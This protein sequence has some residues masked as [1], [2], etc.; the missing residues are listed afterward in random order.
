MEF[1][2]RSKN[3]I[4]KCRARNTITSKEITKILPI[5]SKI[6]TWGDEIYFKIPSII[7]NLEKDSKDVLNLG[8]IAYWNQGNSV[9]IGFGPTPASKNQEIRLASNCNVWADAINPEELLNLSNLEDN[10]DIQIIFS[11]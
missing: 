11:K 7:S 10:D 2:I 8:E 6:N 4:I 9:A 1:E 3:I 5:K